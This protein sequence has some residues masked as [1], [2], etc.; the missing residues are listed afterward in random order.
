VARLRDSART[1][2]FDHEAARQV[3]LAPGQNFAIDFVQRG[4]LRDALTNTR[5]GG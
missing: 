3:T 2:G 1:E 4:R 5:G